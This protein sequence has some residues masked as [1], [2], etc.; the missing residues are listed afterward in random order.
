VA[1]SWLN[2]SAVAGGG[3]LTHTL[4]TS[5]SSWGTAAAAEPPSVNRAPADGRTHVDATLRP[6]SAALPAGSATAQ[7]AAFQVDVVAQ[8]PV[9]ITPR[10]TAS[11]PAGWT[12]TV[13]PQVPK[14][15]VTRHLPIGATA[16]VT[17]QAPAGTPAGAY[18]VRVT[19]S[20]PGTAPVERTASVTVREP[21]TCAGT[22][23]AACPVD[24]GA[25]RTVD[26]TATV[27]APA[28]GDFDG[29]GWSYDAGLL[30]AAG[31]VTWNGVT[32]QAPDPAGTAKNLVPARGQ[33]LLLPVGAH[34][35]V[36][37]VATTHN[38]P[39]TAAVT[40]G[41]TDGTSAPATVTI[42]DWCGTAAP[43]ST[44]V[45]TMPHRIKAGQGVDGPPVSLFAVSLPVAAGK[46]VRSVTLPDDPR[47]RLYA[48]TL[49]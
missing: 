1:K 8:A 45:L 37:L 18:P 36:K 17:V 48:V 22:P 34:E 19:V 38:G 32:Y 9:A 10:V 43:G 35:A 42:A 13:T 33:S 49:A 28:E 44:T 12:E 4:G 27:A 20:A 6:A 39:V 15:L 25:E 30:P 11:V 31:P 24:L 41:Y 16:T 3:T 21:L 46:Q 2:W 5:P 29:G 40:L 14:T 7:Q 26:G 47:L 23:G